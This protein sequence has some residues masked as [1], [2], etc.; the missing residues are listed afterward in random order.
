MI[1]LAPMRRRRKCHR[2]IRY[3]ILEERAEAYLLLGDICDAYLCPISMRPCDHIF[4]DK[5]GYGL[6]R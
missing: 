1:A 4:D 6:D 2:G 5:N 3:D